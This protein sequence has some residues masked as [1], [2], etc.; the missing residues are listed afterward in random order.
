MVNNA[1]SQLIQACDTIQ[2]DILFMI[3]KSEGHALKYVMEPARDRKYC[4]VAY[5]KMLAEHAQVIPNETAIELV[6][7]LIE[8][9]SPTTK[10]S[11]F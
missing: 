11:G 9:A 10:N 5:S 1:S 2:K 3:I 8:T 7:A 6:C 4:L